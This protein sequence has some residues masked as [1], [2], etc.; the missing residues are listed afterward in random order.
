V[1]EGGKEGRREGGSETR[2]EGGISFT[3]RVC[4]DIRN[5]WIKKAKRKR[6]G[7]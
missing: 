3:K 4:E 5:D 1:R 6:N 2:R 7:Y